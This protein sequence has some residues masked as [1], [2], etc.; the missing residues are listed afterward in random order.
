MITTAISR[1]KH[2]ALRYL[3]NDKFIGMSLELYGEFSDMEAGLLEQLLRPGQVVVEVGANI[4]AHSVHLAKRVGDKGLVLAFEPQRVIH[5]ILAENLRENGCTN[6]QAIHAAVGACAGMITVPEVDYASVGNFGGVELGV[7]LGESVPV[8]TID[9]LKLDALNLLKVDVE[10][11]ESDVI[12]GALET[13]GRLRPILY[14]EN[15]RADK[16]AALIAAI[17]DLDY[18]IWWHLPPLFNP[19][20]IRGNRNNIF[21]GIVSINMLCVP[22][23]SQA[24]IALCEVSGPEDDWRRALSPV[25]GQRRAAELGQ[26]TVAVIRP[27]AY[28]DV[29]MASSVLPHLKAEGYHV[30]VYTEQRGEEMLRHDPNVDAIVMYHDMPG[31]IAAGFIEQESGKFDRMINLNEAIEKNMIAIESDL[32]YY[33]PQN[34]RRQVFGGD[35]LERLHVLAGVPASARG[36][37]RQRFYPSDEEAAWARQERAAIVGPVVLIAASGSSPT[38]HWPHVLPFAEQLADR[39]IHVVIA[40]ELGSLKGQA[41][42]ER[43]RLLGTDWPLRNLLA[44]AML[45]DAVVG[46]ETGILNAVAMEPMP[47]IVLLTHSAEGSLT[48]HWVN[49]AEVAGKAAPCWPCHRIHHHMGHCTMDEA[50][51]KALCQAV[52]PPQQVLDAL[53]ARMPLAQP[54]LQ[55][56]A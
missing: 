50:T 51:G 53:F 32:R 36:D 48:Q 40:G 56:A 3:P 12:A 20:N 37:F 21:P 19:G 7:G 6:V 55:Q 41:H 39:G 17:A 23:E 16:S 2:G 49:A 18:Q 14:V 28:G 31:N 1:G 46:Q 42:S 27:G 4:G 5:E 45:A 25:G 43:I 13:I 15:D 38:K 11:M 34:L 9:S 44:F 29:L 52:I 10:G 24:R 22:R 26:K 33:W 54:T 30:T 47:K 8:V 35:Y